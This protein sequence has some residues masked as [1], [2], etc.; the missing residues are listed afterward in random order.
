MRH[1]LIPLSNREIHDMPKRVCVTLLSMVCFCALTFE[2]A[3]GVETV[4]FKTAAGDLVNGK[5]KAKQTVVGE[6]L[7][8][9]LDGAVMLQSDEGRIWTIQPDQIL[10]RQS[11]NNPLVPATADQLKK[12]MLGELPPGFSVYQTANYL[13]LHNTTELYVK[14]VG[15]LFEQLHRGFYAYWKNQG[16]D[17]PK[18]RFPLVALVLADRNSFMKHATSEVGPTASQV[19]G[20]YHLSNNRMTTFNIPNLERNVATIIHEATHQ[21]AYNCGLQCRFADNPK[22]VSE[23]LAMFFESPDFRSASKWRSIGRVNVKNLG[24]F[25]EYMTRRPEDSLTTLISDGKRFLDA[26]QIEAAYGESW[27]L[28]YFLLKTHRKQYVEYLRELSKGTPSV[29]LSPRERILMF[30]KAF[31]TTLGE[32]DKQFLA[33][34][35]RVRS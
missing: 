1:T 23:G 2:N 21:L 17:L 32:L 8:E 33:Y 11:D 19:F 3:S 35:R 13:I 24:R 27:A 9:A 20:Y 22:W 5:P 28:T 10:N 4:T 25:R 15:R 16:W 6:I 29:E 18:P 12:R 34:M 7:V 26:N 14:Q 30:E 31:G